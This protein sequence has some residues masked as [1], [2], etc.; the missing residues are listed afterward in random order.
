M[1]SHKTFLQG[2]AKANSA[3]KAEIDEFAGLTTSRPQE[4]VNST[5]RRYLS[6]IYQNIDLI[7]QHHGHPRTTRT[8]IL[9][10]WQSFLPPIQAL[11]LLPFGDFLAV[12]MLLYLAS[13]LLLQ[14]AMDMK[15]S[16]AS[17]YKA[18]V[19]LNQLN[20]TLDDA[21]LE[22]LRRIW[23]K[24]ETCE[25]FKWVFGEYKV[26][27]W[28][29][30]DTSNEEAQHCHRIAQALTPAELA[31]LDGT[32]GRHFIFAK[33]KDIEGEED[34]DHWQPFSGGIPGDHYERMR[35]PARI[36]DDDDIEVDEWV[37]K[38]LGADG[39]IR[40]AVF[41]AI[42]DNSRMESR[43]QGL[44]LVPRS[45][46]FVLDAGRIAQPILAVKR[47]ILAEKG[48]RKV[49]IPAELRV[50]ILAHLD[51]PVR[52]PYLSSVDIVEAYAPFPER[53]RPSCYVCPSGGA[54]KRVILTCPFKSIYIWNMPLRTF[55][56]FHQTKAKVGWLCKYGV[57]CKGH[58][59]GDDWRISTENDLNVYV[60]KIVK[61][62]CGSATT[63]SQVG[64]AAPTDFTLNTDDEDEKRR[65]RL[66]VGYGPLEDSSNELK[67]NGG[68]FGLTSSMV[69]NKILLGSW[70]GVDE[71]GRSMTS[72][73][74]ALARCIA[75]RN[76]CES[77][78][79]K[80]HSRCDRC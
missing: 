6:Q 65:R 3:L 38:L 27:R 75:D 9:D 66:F 31:A 60:E 39:P 34:E 12:R 44:D 33:K 5:V 23:T 58:H 7:S 20:I 22:S 72:A 68:F 26:S 54:S 35:S 17:A 56:V 55:F 67:M 71:G 62:R 45:L 47:R 30:E 64:F 14:R 78:L 25:D 80:M 49:G 42:H 10:T 16:E 79:K 36:P 46:Q 18:D 37:Y 51:M 15:F 77:A 57:E 76:C 73:Q 32:R 4:E 74:W 43:W 13:G 48:L 59:D 2:I 52:H 24:S 11:S 1:D 50:E 28:R 8:K 41:Y 69:H 70:Q 61:D 29:K 63:L 53:N 21:L 40:E 19:P